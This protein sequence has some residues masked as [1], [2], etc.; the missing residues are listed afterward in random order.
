MAK[1]SYFQFKQFTIH[2]D[3]CAMKVCTD[4]CV[5]G[6]SADLG[7]SK[8]ILD[9]GAGTGL[10]SLMTAQRYPFAHVDAVELDVD[11][12][13]QAID[14]VAASPFSGQISLFN[15]AIQEFAPVYQYDSIITNPPFF[16]SDLLSPNLQKNQ[17]HHSTSLSFNDLLKSIDR[18]LTDKGQFHILLPTDE[19]EVFYQK[20][21]ALDWFMTNNLTLQHNKDKKPFRRIMT[22]CKY[23]FAENEINNSILNIY[24]ENN[25]VYDQEF[26]RLMKDFYMI[27]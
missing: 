7:N 25:K 2:Q 14:N 10:L 20:A 26:V 1:N 9:I 8:R 27:F 22:F 3:K 5:L 18:L 13:L 12:Y 17:A 6:A 21:K 24:G 23:Y 4:A 15:T 19:S 16:Q 11:A